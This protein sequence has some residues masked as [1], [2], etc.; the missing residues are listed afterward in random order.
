MEGGTAERWCKD[1]P[2]T[3]RIPKVEPLHLEFFDFV[4]FVVSF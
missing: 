1:P 2:M 4:C 3:L